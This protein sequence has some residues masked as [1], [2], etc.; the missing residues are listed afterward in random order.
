MR[1]VDLNHRPLGYELAYALR[2]NYLTWHGWERKLNNTNSEQFCLQTNGSAKGALLF[3]YFSFY[4][5]ENVRQAPAKINRKS[6]SRLHCQLL[7]FGQESQ[8]SRHAF[9]RMSTPR[10]LPAGDAS[11]NPFFEVPLGQ[12]WEFNGSG[13]LTDWRKIIGGNPAA[14]LGFKLPDVTLGNLAALV[15]ELGKSLESLLDGTIGS[16]APKQQN[17]TRERHRLSVKLKLI[18]HLNHRCEAFLVA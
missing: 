18:E 6:S 3:V 14:P 15:A 17:G 2:F 16:L 9:M 13:Y 11:Q 5:L 7:T 8:G 1:G 4:V 12:D 10:Y